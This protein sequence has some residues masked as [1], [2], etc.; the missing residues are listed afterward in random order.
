MLGAI[1]LVGL[2]VGVYILY[3]LVQ[4]P[5]ATGG[6]EYISG[7]GR[8]LIYAGALVAFLI[9]IGLLIWLMTYQIDL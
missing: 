7:F 1:Q 8:F 3:R 5:I 6:S 2:V 9:E 4:L